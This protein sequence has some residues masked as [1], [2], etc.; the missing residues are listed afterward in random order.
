MGLLA[1]RTREAAASVVTEPKKSGVGRGRH[2]GGGLSALV[3]YP[4][5]FQQGEEVLTR[6]DDTV[7]WWEEHF[8]ELLNQTDLTSILET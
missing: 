2:D 1:Q 6:T 4:Y 3:A 8:E 5:F 7:G